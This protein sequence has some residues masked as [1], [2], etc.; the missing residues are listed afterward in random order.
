MSG[1]PVAGSKLRAPSKLPAASAGKL[2]KPSGRGDATDGGASK[3]PTS[4]GIRKPSGL[5]PAGSKASSVAATPRKLAGTTVPQT[6]SRAAPAG[7]TPGI[8]D[9]VVVGGK[10]GV[11]RFLGSTKFAP[12]DWAGVELLE[13]QGKNDGTVQGVRYFSCAANHGLFAKPDKL[14]R[15]KATVTKTSTTSA[16]AAATAAAAPRAG[17]VAAAAAG[18]RTPAR[19]QSVSSAKVGDRVLV[20]GTKR[21]VLRY[22]GTTDFAAGQW[23]GIEL[24]KAEGKNDGKV[25][26]KRYFTCPANHGLFSPVHKLEVIESSSPLSRASSQADLRAIPALGPAVSSSNI[27]AALAAT[28]TV[29]LT[30]LEAQ[31]ESLREQLERSEHERQS[32]VGKLH[33]EER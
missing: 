27:A 14:E 4:E 15:D 29:D 12:G 23:A 22:L 30:G 10:R 31:V 20:S 3:P 33:D 7:G 24:D 13:A 8:G 18:T 2:Q 25:Q 11:I 32:L 6:P 28:S 26:G 17:P 19:R 21:G 9:A 1:I 5:A 16:A